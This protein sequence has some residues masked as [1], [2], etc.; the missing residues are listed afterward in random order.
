MLV[1]AQGF[2]QVAGQRGILCPRFAGQA[3]AGQVAGQRADALLLQ[4]VQQRWSRVKSERAPPTTNTGGAR[5][6]SGNSRRA[7][8][9]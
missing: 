7:C 9:R 8:W 4:T 6:L 5:S 3:V 1:E 2:L